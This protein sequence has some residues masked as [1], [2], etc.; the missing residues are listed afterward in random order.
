MDAQ[1]KVALIGA[2]VGA[3]AAVV[4]LSLTASRK[5]AISHRGRLIATFVA[6]VGLAVFL[7]SVALGRA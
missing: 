5:H 3:A 7:F 1:T 6:L 2:S 4:G